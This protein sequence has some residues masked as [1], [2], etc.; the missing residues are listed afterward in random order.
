MPNRSLWTLL[1]L[2]LYIPSLAGSAAL[3]ER[4]WLT[5]SE[6]NERRAKILKSEL[7]DL[8]EAAQTEAA[9]AFKVRKVESLED[10]RAF[11]RR[12]ETLTVSVAFNDS[13]AQAEEAAAISLELLRYETSDLGKASIALNVVVAY[14]FTRHLLKPA[15][16][17]RLASA[18][19]DYGLSFATIGKGNPDNPFNNWWGVTRSA[20]GLCLLATLP[21]FPEVEAPLR[22][23]RERVASYLLNYGD[24]GHYYEG[25]GY[26]IYAFSQWGPFALACRAS[27]GVDIAENAPG[28]QKMGVNVHSLTVPGPQV[29]GD[30]RLRLGRRVFWNDDGSNF[31]SP[32]IA[33]LYFPFSN[34][35]DQIALLG[36]YNRIGGNAGDRTYLEIDDSHGHALWTLLYYP[37]GA[38]PP[39]YGEGLN[40]NL[41]DHKN[42]LAVFRDRFQDKNDSVFAVY[43]KSFHGGG[44]EQQDAGSFRFL[45]LGTSWAHAGGQA[46]P[47]AH[48]Q[49]VLLK[50]GIQYDRTN[51]YQARAGKVSY[52]APTENGGS[53]SVDLGAV[54]GTARVRRHFAIRYAPTPGLRAVIGIWDEIIEKSEEQNEWSWSM[55]FQQS[56]Q[57]DTGSGRFTLTDPTSGATLSGWFSEQHE[58]ESHEGPPSS[59]TFSSGFQ[60]DYPGA[61]YL[62][63]HSPESSKGFFTVLVLHEGEQPKLVFQGDGKER[64]A[65]I[66]DEVTLSIDQSKWYL[67][68]LRIQLSD[69]AQPIAALSGPTQAEIA[70]MPRD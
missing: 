35:L 61:R 28:I 10:R 13:R 48:Y 12:L 18:I 68:P 30:E 6:W 65:I 43:A 26:G 50:N 20:A 47:Q 63:A 1:A 7:V 23:E 14:A 5:D 56:L 17:Q 59:R 15:T 3:S 58:I 27:L 4:L 38:E 46:K 22:N 49:N 69:S 31:P 66:N 70:N 36:S 44:H 45:S 11:V 2:T 29:E 9:R 41:F 34:A 32:S 8:V 25:T 62:T 37:L 54:Y 21:S 19:R 64:R 33:S 52:Y 57:L 55:C 53:I 60:R 16:R 24:G 40:R 39:N 67:G 42:G 51:R